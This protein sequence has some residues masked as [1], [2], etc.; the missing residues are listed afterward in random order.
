MPNQSLQFAKR[1]IV[2]VFGF[3]L[4]AVGL[5]MCIPLVPGPGLLVVIGALAILAVEFVWA[6]RLLER[7]KTQGN[8]LRER[9]RAGAKTDEQRTNER[10]K[11]AIETK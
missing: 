2:A 1:V 11:H 8:R 5:V 6:R 4:L 7:V 10:N 3:T 9:L